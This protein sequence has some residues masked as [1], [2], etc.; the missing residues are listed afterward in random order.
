LGW[1]LR[2]AGYLT[3]DRGNEDSKEQMLEEALSCLRSGIS[4]MIF[5]EGTRSADKRIGFF[6]RGAFT[7]ALTAEVPLLPV[8]LDGSGNIL[9]KHGI[10][11]GAHR[12]IRIKVLDPVFP[13]NF[14]TAVPEELAVLFQRKMTQELN[15]MRRCTEK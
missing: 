2:M 9:P 5:P 11:F 10:I 12:K 14:G 3:V 1:Y 7:L 15:D 4:V 13:V 6:K 8:I